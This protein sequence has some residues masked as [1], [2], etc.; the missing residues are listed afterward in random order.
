MTDVREASGNFAPRPTG[1]S[2]PGAPQPDSLLRLLI[3]QVADYAIFVLDREG[4]VASW[5][6]GAQRSKGYA[7]REII[8]RHFSV[9]YPEEDL[10]AGKPAYELVAAARDGRFEDEGWRLR[11]DGSRF[12]ANVVITAL[13]DERGEVVGFAKVTRDL[14]AR[15][16]AEENARRLAA[17]EAAREEAER[18]AHELAVLAEQLEQHAVELE[19]QT[20]EAQSLSEEL[21]AT[22]DELLRALH[23]VE[24]AERFARGI[25]ESISDPFVVHDAD[26]RFRYINA[27]A[28]KVFATS[29]QELARDPTGRVVW[30][31]YPELRGTVFERE[32]RRAME[33]RVPVTFEAFYRERGEWSHLFCYPLPDGGLAT[34]W[35]NVT[36]RKKSEEAA[37]YLARASAVLSS[38]LDYE[39]TLT[40]LANLIVPELADWCTVDIVDAGAVRR[41]AVAHVRPENVALARELSERYP[42]DEHADSGVPHVIRTGTSEIYPEISDALLVESAV[43][44]D[45]LRILRELG[46]YSAVVVPLHTGTRALGALTLVS[47]ESRRRYTIADLRLAEELG[48]RAATAMENSRLFDEARS[49][50]DRIARLQAVTAGLATTLSADAVAETVIREGMAALGASTA[51]FCLLTPDASALEIVRASG[52]SEQTLGAYRTFPVDAPLPLSESVRTGAPVFLASRADVVQRYPQLR[53]ANAKSTNESW[54]ALPLLVNDTPIGGLAF[55]FAAPGPL[56]GENRAF[57]LALARQAAQALERARLY[58]AERVARAEAEAANRAKSEFLATMSHELRT[59][60]NAIA[61]HTQ[62]LSMQLHGPVTDKQAETLGR[63]ERSQRHLQSLIEDILSFA[64]LEAGRLTLDIE[65]VPL[66]ELIV[67]LEA[68]VGPQ[69]REK[70]LTFDFENCDEALAASADAEKVRQILVNLLSNAIKFTPRGGS[71]SIAGDRRGD[72][73]VIAVRDT[74]IGIPPDKLEVIFDPFVQLGRTL[75]TSSEGTGLGLSISRDLARRMGGDLRVESEVGAGSTFVLTLPAARA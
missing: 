49:S 70:G 8:G 29:E 54:M 73:V 59:P 44:A 4:R 62:L 31:I 69:V 13:R 52:L 30:E 45:H 63:I 55:G 33:D 26:W 37:H 57:A 60:L 61:G 17:E 5:N 48:R 3:E 36:D 64:R 28:A 25:L 7:A 27:A 51:V 72:E 12:W 18:R 46:L 47:A 2:T 40:E 68:L 66:R 42:P 1:A 34:Q 58:A 43:D 10:A 50:A 75:T 39:R 21:E 53:E 22:N 74:G 35:K 20:E 19:A 24:D 23:L 14:T 56:T 15:R 38:S 32:M 67:G 16:Q 9:F 6:P 41:L 11:K 71:V 65:D